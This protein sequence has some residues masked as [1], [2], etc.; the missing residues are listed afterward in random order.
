MGLRFLSQEKGRLVKSDFTRTAREMARLAKEKAI[1]PYSGF[2]VGAVA[3]GINDSG[4]WVFASGANIEAACSSVGICAERVAVANLLMQ[5][6]KPSLVCID[7]DKS[8]V[9][10]CGV[11]LQFMNEWRVMIGTPEHYGPISDYLPRPYRGRSPK[12]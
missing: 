4:S 12:H 9:V 11:C 8:D 6:V 1:A 3:A 2:K 10:P 5:G 7:A